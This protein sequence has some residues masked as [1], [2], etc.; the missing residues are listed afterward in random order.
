MK[1]YVGNLSFNTTEQQ[2]ESMFAEHGP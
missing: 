1:L 2:L